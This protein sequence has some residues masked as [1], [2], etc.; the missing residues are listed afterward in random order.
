MGAIVREI[1]VETRFF[2]SS[3]VVIDP[4][5]SPLALWRCRRDGPATEVVSGGDQC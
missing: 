1:S 3:V 5:I 4:P 2:R